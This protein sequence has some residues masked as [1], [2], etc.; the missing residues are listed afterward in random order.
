MSSV[1]TFVGLD[2]HKETIRVCV[3]SEDG[4]QLF[5]R[6]VSNDA[7]EV[8]NVVMDFGLPKVIAIEACCG[9]ADMATELRERF[10]WNVQ[11]AD[12]HAVTAMKRGRDKTDKQD[13]F[14]LADLARV[15]HLPEVWLPDETTRQ[16]R[17][18]IRFRK[19]LTEFRRKTKQ[20]IRGILND[21]RA[22][23]AR[24]NAWTK[25]WI[26]WLLTS[27]QIGD[28]SRWVIQAQ[29][30]QLADY[31]KQIKEIDRRLAEVTAED[32]EVQELLKQ[33][34]VGLV[35]AVTLRAELGTFRRFYSG[36]Q[37]SRYCGVTPCNRSSGCKQ[38]DA[39]LVKHA[40]NSLR[41]ILIETAHRLARFDPRWK[42]MKQK[43][44]RRGKRNNVATAA[45]ANR[46]LRWLYHQMVNIP[47]AQQALA[48]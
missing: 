47:Q 9:A 16:L 39:G 30:R 19:Q 37:L 3:L 10:E 32:T 4:T 17:R 12:P 24:A 43:L 35:T 15:D 23:D 38:A 25:K 33:K 2:Y 26:K 21:E 13:A 36:K 14:W 1:F 46:W 22:Q 7:L 29:L 40:N 41:T 11:L 45:V 6:D 28:Q 18:L 8:A 27:E 44:I 31:E 42:E 34:G 5:N 48:A 20:H